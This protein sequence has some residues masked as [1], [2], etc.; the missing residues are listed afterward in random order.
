MN[1]SPLRRGRIVMLVDNN[2][3]FDSRV[4]KQ[5]MSAA[6]RGWDVT[7]LGRERHKSDA[8]EWPLGGAKI[9]T[10]FVPMPM[11]QRRL[12]YRWAP[13]R[14]PF[15]YRQSK[16]ATYRTQQAKARKIDLAF[17]QTTLSPGSAA[18]LRR[19]WLVVSLFRAKVEGR[20]VSYRVARTHALRRRR[21][22]MSGPLD[23][24]TTWWWTRTMGRRSWRRLDPN[25]WDWELAYGPVVD[26][27]QPDLIHANDF[28]MLA[29]GARAKVRAA[30]AGRPVKLVWDAHEYLPGIKP[31]IAHPRWHTAQC[32]IESEFAPLADAVVTVVE[33]LADM[34][35][36]RHA[37]KERP[38]VVLNAP[39]I[40]S[41]TKT[42]A[43]R[44]I[45]DVCGLSPSVPL[46]VYSGAAAPQ[47][48]L[49][50]MVDSLSVLDDVHVVLVVPKLE[51]HYIQKLVERADEIGVRERLH[52]LPYVPIGDIVT[53]LSTADVGVIPVHHWPNHEISLGT[54][55]FEYSH[56]RLPILVSD[57]K[58]MADEVRS[59]GQGEVFVAED[60]EDYVRKARWLLDDRDR[61]VRA[62][63]TPGLLDE[64]TWEAQ[65]IKLDRVYTRLLTD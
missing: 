64:W 63:D 54:K 23:R 46:M 10:I 11:G 14:S 45:R 48:G 65:A 13:L 57:V 19:I 51:A 34:L 21:E 37:L 24:F 9:L 38:T 16:L 53:F 47:R 61:Y 55:F 36:E 30:A 28:R 4:Q 26:R 35:V 15:A 42:S 43:V 49:G 62:Y 2:V 7:L 12:E 60:L 20:W 22:A 3:A 18:S 5:A 50:L 32:A 8:S 39:L 41:A 27:L 59:S 25:A 6:E 52:V 1:E 40:T 29:I 33:P 31:W 56:A 44:N 58:A 17:R